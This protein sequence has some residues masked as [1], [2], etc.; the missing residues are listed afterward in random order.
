MIIDTS[1]LVAVFAREKG[2]MEFVGALMFGGGTIPAPILVEFL[3]VVTRKKWDVLAARAFVTELKDWGHEIRP[4][5]EDDAV[6]ADKANEQ[7]GIGLG[8]GGKLNL[9][10]LMTYAVAK[11]C[12]L[13]IL[14]T[15]HDFSSTD[16][17]IHP[18]SRPE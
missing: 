9:L 3:R 6:L 12:D 11:R 15:G 16:I 2:Y 8:H 18:A 13:P 17:A 7:Y 5:T 14:C 10:D 1:A 4:F